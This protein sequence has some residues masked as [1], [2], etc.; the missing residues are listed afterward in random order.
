MQIC[1]MDY[2]QLCSEILNLDGKVRYAGVYHTTSGKIFEKIQSGIT[3]YL[4]QE[5]TQNSVIHAYMRWKTRQHYSSSVGEPIYAMAKY[6]KINRF[7]M[8]CGTNALLLVNTEP[9]LEPHTIIDDI[10]KLIE[11]FSDDPNYHP[12]SPSFSF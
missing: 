5:Q 10:I 12:R 9:D 4:N 7:T 2:N 1:S 11:K 6:T 3:R 8:P